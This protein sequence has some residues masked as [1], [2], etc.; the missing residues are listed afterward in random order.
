MKRKCI[1]EASAVP[2]LLIVVAGILGGCA[3]EPVGEYSARQYYYE[4]RPG[5]TRTRFVRTYRYGPAPD[6]AGIQTYRNY[7]SMEPVGERVYYG[8]GRVGRTYDAT[9]GNFERMAPY[10]PNSPTSPSQWW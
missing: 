1:I 6:A 7:R 10:G 3:T 8:Y 2:A 4:S 9:T 5:L